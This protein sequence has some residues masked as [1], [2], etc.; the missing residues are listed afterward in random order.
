MI[1]FPVFIFCPDIPTDIKNLAMDPPPPPPCQFRNWLELPRDVTA[2][3]LLRL[4][5]VEI[6][7]CAQKV[8]LLWRNL[9][10]DLSMWRK[11][12]MRNL[13]DLWDMPYDL[14]T[15]CRHAVDRSCGQ[16]VDINV[17][18]FDTDELLHYIAESSSQ[19]KRLR[20]V[21]CYNISVEGLSE[22]AAKLPLLEDLEISYGPLS[23]E[24]LE[25]VGRCCPL[26]K[27][28]KFN[29][30]GY[31][32]PRIECDEEAIA[33]AENMTELRHL[34]LF[35][36][37][38][39]NDGLKAVLDGCHHL[40]SLD[41][42]Q[43]FNVTLTG[44]LGRRCTERIKYLRSPCDSTN[45]YEFD[46]ELHDTGSFDDDYPSGFSDIDYFSDDYGHYEFSSDSDDPDYGDFDD[47]R[48]FY[49]Y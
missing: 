12:D 42:R 32:R 4:G 24:P 17:E 39:T 47:Y 28:L 1:L 31:R 22:V 49:M 26:L 46:A 21:C 2:S 34:Q 6:L 11:I 33:I 40:E 30:Q 36:N 27:S 38:L 8:C 43:C 14:E 3:I 48:E 10:K 41:L 7:T 29:S 35:G 25:A 45:D 19:V 5:A 23:K 16:L 18:Y 15:M 20:L 44:N 37:K 9:C 13:G